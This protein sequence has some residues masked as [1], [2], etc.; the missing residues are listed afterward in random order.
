MSNKIV[1]THNRFI[2]NISSMN[3][4]SRHFEALG[5]G[6]ENVTVRE[7]QDIPSLERDK[8]TKITFTS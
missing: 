7:A 1:H 8:L 4:M 5:V 3:K 2:I 6:I